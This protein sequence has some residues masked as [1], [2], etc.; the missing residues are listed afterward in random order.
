MTKNLVIVGL[1][2]TSAIF[3]VNNKKNVDKLAS[4]NKATLYYSNLYVSYK[5]S[6]QGTA[7]AYYLIGVRCG[8]DIG[9]AN[10]NLTALQTAVVGVE[11]WSKLK[12]TN[13]QYLTL[14]M[15]K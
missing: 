13:D 1:I 10:P 9:K 4:A 5:D 2:I 15:F 12:G 6:A 3:L 14:D 11:Y 7:R 8:K